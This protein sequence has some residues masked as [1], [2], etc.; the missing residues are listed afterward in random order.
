MHYPVHQT[1]SCGSAAGF[2][3]I[4]LLVVLSIMATLLSIAAPRYF[5]SLDKARDA[6]L[7]TDLRILREAIDKYRADNGQLP[8]DL[9]ALV[10][11][12]YVRAI[13]PDPITDSAGTWV[14]VPHPDGV[15]LGVFDVRS[16]APGIGRD[17]TGFGSW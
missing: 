4:E 9:D 5:E 16:G 10:Q 14:A 6:A 12:R 15:T 2:T 7:K 8:Q 17:G 13:P 3:L 11:G 1:A